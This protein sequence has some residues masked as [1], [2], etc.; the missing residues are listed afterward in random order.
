MLGFRMLGLRALGFS[1]YRV[2]SK[3][4]LT[5]SAA[6]KR[7]ECRGLPVSLGAEPLGTAGGIRDQT[8]RMKDT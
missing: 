2:L 7:C 1:L 6:R 3:A 4:H 5:E 8:F